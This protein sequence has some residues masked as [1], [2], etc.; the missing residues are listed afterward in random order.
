MDK[1][2]LE[3]TPNYILYTQALGD[4]DA[5]LDNIKDSL[6]NTD[7]G[8]YFGE[9]NTTLDNLVTQTFELNKTMNSIAKS[10]RL[11]SQRK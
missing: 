1:Q 2:E 6:N 7:N 9:I 8:S 10:L 11:I 3:N 4:I 5:T